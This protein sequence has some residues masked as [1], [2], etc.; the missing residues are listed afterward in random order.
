MNRAKLRIC[1]KKQV[2]P[3]TRHSS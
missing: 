1:Y 3:S 2:N